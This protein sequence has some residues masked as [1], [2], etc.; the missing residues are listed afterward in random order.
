MKS[1]MYSDSDRAR[2]LEHEALLER[3]H[4]EWVRSK[5]TRLWAVNICRQIAAIKGN[6]AAMVD[7][8]ADPGFSDLLDY[9]GL[10]ENGDDKQHTRRDQNGH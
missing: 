4:D 2:R 6:Y 8:D 10:T 9:L 7:P 5:S 1:G 3:K